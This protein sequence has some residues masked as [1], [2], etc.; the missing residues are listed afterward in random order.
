M[1]EKTR[2]SPHWSFWIIGVVAL[3]WHVLGS[4]NFLMQMNARSVAQMPESFRAVIES[5][6]VWAT[7]AFAVAVFGGSIGCILLL[8]R[9]SK[10][11]YLFVASIIGVIVQVFPL[12]GMDD[13]QLGIWIGSLMSLAVAGFMIWYSTHANS[14]AWIG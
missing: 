7:F 11:T 4:V 1:N 5:R 9:K 3:V 12:S 8:L 6:P 13:V 14:K 10:P 2:T